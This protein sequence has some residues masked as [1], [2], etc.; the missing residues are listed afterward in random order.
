[1]RTLLVAAALAALA[2]LAVPGTALADCDAPPPALVDGIQT[3]RVVFVGKVIALEDADRTA[4]FDV[5]WVWKGEGVQ[6]Q[7]VVVG[8]ADASSGFGPADRVFQAGITYLVTS[9]SATQPYLADRCT[10]TRP[11]QGVG[12]AIPPTYQDAVGAA[13]GTAPDPIPVVAEGTGSMLAGPIVPIIFG[14]LVVLALVVVLSRMTRG[15]STAPV[16]STKDT[17]PRSRRSGRP[18]SIGRSGERF[19]GAFRRSGVGQASKLRGIRSKQERRS[20]GR[21]TKSGV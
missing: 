13:T 6:E 15:P 4:T 11:Y 5:Q 14:G 21:R 7:V 1:M 10:T 12:S 8:A 17:K 2:V 9:P 3:S 20:V 19:S 18:P 16:P